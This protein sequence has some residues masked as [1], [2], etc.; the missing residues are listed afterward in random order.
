M[1]TL[2]NKTGVDNT[3][4]KLH[5]MIKPLRVELIV[6]HERARIGYTMTKNL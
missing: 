3:N 1:I 4:A 6:H 2:V 5:M